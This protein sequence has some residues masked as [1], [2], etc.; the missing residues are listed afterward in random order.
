MAEVLSVAF[1]EWAVVIRALGQ[2]EQ[3]VILRK[4]GIHEKDGSFHVE[5]DTFL[6]YPTYEHQKASDLSFKGQ[7]FLKEIQRDFP[8]KNLERVTFNFFARVEDVVWIG[9]RVS[10]LNLDAFHIWS[11][12]ALMERFSRAPEQGIYAL[13]VRVYELSQ[14]VSLPN[15]P[16]YGGCRSWV[17]LQTPVTLPSA[18]PVLSDSSFQSKLQEIREILA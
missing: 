1:K 7:P 2:G 14:A 18:K 12:T 11:E 16:A 5:H 10:L 8:L 6:L 17:S 13:L 15:L 3:I 4:G 9:E